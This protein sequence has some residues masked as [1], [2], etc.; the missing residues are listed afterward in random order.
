MSVHRTRTAR[1]RNSS[2]PNTAA[3][4][5]GRSG[6]V[7]AVLSTTFMTSFDG[8][9]RPAVYQR[10]TACGL[11]GLPSVRQRYEARRALNAVYRP[12]LLAEDRRYVLQRLDLYLDDDVIRAHHLVQLDD[13]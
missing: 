3:T 11:A 13:M 10:G 6:P 7:C 2:P 8:M 12:Y 4:P 1:S 9:N 5:E